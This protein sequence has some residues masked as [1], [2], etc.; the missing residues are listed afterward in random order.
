MASIGINP[1]SKT[2]LGTF[3][4]S[5]VVNSTSEPIVAVCNEHNTVDTMSYSGIVNPES[6]VFLPNITRNYAGWNTPFVIQ[7]L[8]SAVATVTVEF[9]NSS[10]T[11]VKT[12][13]DQNIPAGSSLSFNPAGM[14]NLGGSFKGSVIAICTNVKPIGAIVNEQNITGQNMAYTGFMD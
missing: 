7:N 1:I 5:V 4:G 6:V 14:T 2:S 9:Y 11:K 8:D 10:G 13:S 12:I 3:Q